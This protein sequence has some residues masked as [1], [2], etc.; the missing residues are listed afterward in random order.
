MSRTPAHRTA[1][2]TVSAHVYDPVT[3]ADADLPG[4]IT[5]GLLVGQAGTANLMQPD[6]TVRANVP[7][8]EGYNPIQVRQVRTGG[9][10]TNIWA[11]Y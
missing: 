8:Q 1:D 10:A 6:G 9:D 5:R 2:A 11:L 7:L 3:K 4:G